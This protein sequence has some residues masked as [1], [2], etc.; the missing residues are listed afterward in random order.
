VILDLSIKV[1]PRPRA[2]LTL[3]CPMQQPEA[4]ALTNRW[5]GQPLPVSATLWHA[6]RLWV[7]LSGAQAA[8]QGAARR[9]ANETGGA[10]LDAEEARALWRSVRDQQHP[11]FGSDGHAGQPLWRVSLPSTAAPLARTEP[12]LVEWNGALRWFHSNAAA[13]AIRAE[14]QRLGGHAT[15]FRGG[16]AQQRDAGVFTPLSAPLAAIHRRL[17]AEFDPAGIF[18][19]GR[20]YA[21]F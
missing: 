5:A 8:V 3:L 21:D 4:L 15:L 14:A 19:P 20:M 11:F 13:T 2:E 10:T 18:N 6:D 12:Q 1:L 17:K 16:D 7:R 9:L